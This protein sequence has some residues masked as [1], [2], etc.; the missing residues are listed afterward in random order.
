MPASKRDETFVARRAVRQIG[1]QDA[2]HGL[3]RILR[4]DVAID[5]LT[6]R[7]LRAETAADIDVIALD[8]RAVFGVLHLG[9][10]Q[11]LVVEEPEPQCKGEQIEESIIAGE[12]EDPLQPGEQPKGQP[13]QTPRSPGE[14]GRD[15]LE[16]QRG[17][18]RGALREGGKVVRV[19]PG[20]G[21]LLYTS[22]AA[23]D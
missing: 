19:P 8:L 18:G 4:L 7:G 2:L 21:C 15:T 6:E 12:R 17:R 11:R 1:L 22:D 9:R 20:A 5:F 23:D 10:E 16:G 14:E 3:R 13:A